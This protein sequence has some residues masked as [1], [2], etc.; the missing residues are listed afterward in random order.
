MSD[1][2]TVAVLGTGLMGAGMARQLSAAGHEVRAWNRTLS[3]AQPL[4]ADGVRVVADAAEAVRG[5]DA[6]VTILLDGFATAEVVGGA[7]GAFRPD[8]VWLQAGTVGPE[9]QTDLAALAAEH[10]LLFLDSPV[11]GTRSVAEA[12]QLTVLAAGPEAARPVAEKVFDAIGRVTFWLPGEAADAPASKLKLVLNNWVLALT[13]ATGETLALAKAL[14]VD[15]DRFFAAID[16]GSMD[17]PYL[18]MK[19]EAIR[20]GDLSPSFTLKGA[21]KDFDLIVAAAESA[22]VRLDLAAAGAARFH[23]AVAQGHG[24]ED[25][26]AGYFASWDA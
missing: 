7:A 11:L 24:D 9:A 4:A 26:A 8:A 12:G 25:M 6:V 15:P 10:G 2:L 16:G 23:R 18:R 22:G 13:A 14:D 5:A 21:A 3:R 1:S 20:S 19:A 17:T